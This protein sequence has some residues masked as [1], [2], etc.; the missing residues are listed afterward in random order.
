[1]NLFLAKHNLQDE[2]AALRERQRRQMERQQ[3]LTVKRSKRHKTAQ[4]VLLAAAADLLVEE[5][6]RASQSAAALQA[7]Q[8]AKDE[9]HAEELASVSLE[10]AHTKDAASEEV[11]RLLGRLHAAKHDQISV[12]RTHE[13]LEADLLRRLALSEARQRALTT[14]LQRKEAQ[15]LAAEAEAAAKGLA[16]HTLQRAMEARL[17][18]LHS[19]LCG[20]EEASAHA[21]AAAAARLA[22]LQDCLNALQG[23]RH[24]ADN[25]TLPFDR[26]PRQASNRR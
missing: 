23:Y 18:G 24:G 11:N 25:K 13:Q 22:N 5:Q 2:L 19:Q 15:R 17:V 12:A 14:Q 4:D 1:M 6:A 9:W 10:L 8:Q 16:L 26:A 20:Q 7:E 21:A 3:Q